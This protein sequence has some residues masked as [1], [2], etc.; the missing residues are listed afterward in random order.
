MISDCLD[1]ICASILNG[2]IIVKPFY[3]PIFDKNGV[4]V[5]C[6]MLG[7]YSSHTNDWQSVFTLKNNTDA[8]KFIDLI[9]LHKITQDV[10]KSNLTNLR[11]LSINIRMNN[12]DRF[13]VQ[14]IINLSKTLS[15]VKCRLKIEVSELDEIDDVKI[16]LLRNL[17]DNGILISLDDFGVNNS[18]LLRILELPVDEVKIDRDVFHASIKSLKSFVFL[19]RFISI[20]KAEDISITCEG[21]ET[22]LQL[23]L[24]NI[25]G[26]DFFQGFFLGRPNEN[27]LI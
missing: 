16:A 13:Y 8:I 9:L 5:G 10:R 27:I 19:K 2:D 3:Q 23:F 22:E 25:L 24:A 4:N 11:S 6:E 18:N 17:K 26:A 12:M 7:R 15:L 20:T 21:I 1:D 14:K